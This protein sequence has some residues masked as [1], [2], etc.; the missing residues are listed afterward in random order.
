MDESIAVAAF[1]SIP[2]YPIK[3]KTKIKRDSIN[4]KSKSSLVDDW[5][6]LTIFDSIDS[7][8]SLA[9]ITSKIITSDEL[10]GSGI[11]FNN[12]RFSFSSK[13]EKNEKEKQIQK[14][15]FS[16]PKISK[17]SNVTYPNVGFGE[18]DKILILC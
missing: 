11:N 16:K 14:N 3:P 12:S 9:Q 15:S 5:F 6:N 17:V 13:N 8:L 7:N 18:R 10:N 2:K 1:N 4:I